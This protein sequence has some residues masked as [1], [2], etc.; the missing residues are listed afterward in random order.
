MRFPLA[1]KSMTS[2]DLERPKRQ[3]C[4]NKQNFLSLNSFRIKIRAQ[5]SIVTVSIN[6]IRVNSLQV[7]IGRIARSSLRQQGFLVRLARRSSPIGLRV[8][9]AT[10]LRCGGIFIAQAYHQCA[11][12]RIFAIGQ[13]YEFMNTTCSRSYCC[14]QTQHMIGYWHKPVVRLSVCLSVCL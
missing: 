14:T 7:Y 10:C 2:D 6:K 1:P 11:S 12:Q 9:V 3:S 5:Y 13:Y 4:R 8:A